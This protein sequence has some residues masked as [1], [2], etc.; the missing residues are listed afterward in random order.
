M[1]KLLTLSLACVLSQAAVLNDFTVHQRLATPPTW[2]P[3]GSVVVDPNF[4]SNILRVT[5]AADSAAECLAGG[6]PGPVDFSNGY[7]S[8]Y[9]SFSAHS[10]HFFYGAADGWT[11]IAD[12]DAAAFKLSNKRRITPNLPQS[13]TYWSRFDDDLMYYVSGMQIRTYRVSTGAS[14]VVADLTGRVPATWG[15]SYFL[16]RGMDYNDNRI[17]LMP[18]TVNYQP[19]TPQADLV[20][21]RLQDK[22]Y[23]PFFTTYDKSQLSADGQTIMTVYGPIAVDTGAYQPTTDAD[24]LAAH[25]DMGVGIPWVGASTAGGGMFGYRVYSAAN[26]AAVTKVYPLDAP[27][28]VDWN[29]Q[30]QH[31]SMRG[32]NKGVLI[33]TVEMNNGPATL[34]SN[35]MVV[36]YPGD[37]TKNIRVANTWTDL[38]NNNTT[39]NYGWL[40]VANLSQDGHFA[41]FV[42]TYGHGRADVYIVGVQ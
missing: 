5:D 2:G 3:A 23:G 33:S 8:I 41:S 9:D 17:H 24:Y 30:V 16:S 18:R 13:Q 20:Y 12:F 37:T 40:P 42:A 38:Q 7:S 11:Y 4:K 14:A 39:Y 32:A 6:I 31:F 29:M 34:Y 28:P 36:L 22:V 27:R 1:R 21:D 26:L 19:L 10:K 25:A 35:E 15:I